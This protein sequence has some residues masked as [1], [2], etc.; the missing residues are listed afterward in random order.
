MLLAEL[1]SIHLKFGSVMNTE[2]VKARLQEYQSSISVRR[3]KLARHV[4]HREEPLPQDFAEQAVELE[5]NETML[6]LEDELSEQE[7]EVERALA[8]LENGSY[9]VCV[10]CGESIAEE[11]LQA[12]PAAALC[13][14][15][16]DARD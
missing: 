4:H 15:C 3:A 2:D 14:D 6:A 5:N 7:R 13:F 11:R 1:I 16:A 10:E 8:R 12:L 9:G